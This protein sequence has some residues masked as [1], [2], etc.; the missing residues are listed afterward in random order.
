MRCLRRLFRRRLLPM[1]VDRAP[2]PRAR[3]NGPEAA[4]KV[5]QFP[6]RTAACER[7]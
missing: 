6:R 1:P 3:R 4:G 2:D 5:I 7:E